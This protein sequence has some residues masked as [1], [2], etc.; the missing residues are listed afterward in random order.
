LGASEDLIDLEPAFEAIHRG[1]C[2][3]YNRSRSAGDFNSALQELDG[4]FLRY[5]AGNATFINPSIRDFTSNILCRTPA[6]A[7]GM[8]ADVTRFKQIKN[9]WNL[10]TKRQDQPLMAALLSNSSLLQSNVER[11]MYG[12]SF[13]RAMGSMGFPIRHYVDMYEENRLDTICALAEEFR[14]V[15]FVDLAITY[16]EFLVS[17]WRKNNIDFGGAIRVLN[18]VKERSWLW[19]QGGNSVYRVVLDGLLDHLDE[20]WARDWATVLEFKSATLE[21]SDMDELKLTDGIELYRLQG[22]DHDRDNC[23]DV[24]ELEDLR[25]SLLELEERFGIDFAVTI[26]SIEL[27]IAE[28]EENAPFDDGEGGGFARRSDPLPTDYVTEGEVREMFKTLRE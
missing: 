25:G 10:A 7:L 19:R 8:I 14:N 4:A 12:E 18:A 27:D 15:A 23:S 11:T 13:R 5:D 1:A 22:V 17:H 3:R 9:L 16:A 28:R 6:I 26:E 24:A 21:W 20:A 2:N